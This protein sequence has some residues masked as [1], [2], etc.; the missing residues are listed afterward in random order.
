MIAL[1]SV[2]GLSVRSGDRPVL[3]DVDLTVE[4]REVHA[5]V[6]ANGAG[7]SSLAY[8]VMGATAYTP[9]GGDV[10]FDGESLVTHEAAIGRVDAR[11]LETLM[12]RGLSPDE[13]ADV[14]V[15]GMLA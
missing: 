10:V 12:T 5:L 14:I 8:A 7:K 3:T 4:E 6:G 15:R 1:L 9:T 11:Q 13:A 2:R